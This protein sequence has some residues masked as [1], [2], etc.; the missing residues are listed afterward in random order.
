MLHYRIHGSFDA[1]FWVHKGLYTYLQQRENKIIDKHKYCV[2][3]WVM[4]CPQ[5]YVFYGVFNKHLPSSSD[6]N[7]E[8]NYNHKE[9]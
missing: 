9:L 7:E 4:L 6:S 8:E 5:R 1:R 3:F 2:N